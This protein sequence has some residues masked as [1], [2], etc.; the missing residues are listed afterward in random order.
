MIFFAP[1]CVTSL[2]AAVPGHQR[3][4]V[5]FQCLHSQQF[6]QY[7]FRLCSGAWTSTS[8]CPSLSW[9]PS[10]PASA[11]P[12][13]TRGA[14]TSEQG[15]MSCNVTASQIGASNLRST[16]ATQQ[17][18]C[19]PGC[20]VQHAFKPGLLVP[21][22]RV[23]AHNRHPHL[24]PCRPPCLPLLFPHPSAGASPTSPTSAPATTAAAGMPT[25]RSRASPD[26][27]RPARTT[28]RLTR[29]AAMCAAFRRLVPR[30]LTALCS[31]KRVHGHPLH[32]HMPAPPN[33][34]HVCSSASLERV[35][36]S[37]LYNA[38]RACAWA[39]RGQYPAPH[40]HLP[41][42]LHRRGAR[43]QD[44]LHA[45]VREIGR[46]GAVELFSASGR[47]WAAVT[48]VWCLFGCTGGMLYTV[49]WLMPPTACH[50]PLQV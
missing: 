18:C 24:A 2:C 41:A 46:D 34:L 22:S 26:P 17:L 5:H 49:S 42:L 3:V 37:P 28:C 29:C 4:P 15:L 47:D 11:A 20:A 38:G 13:T 10:A 9:T 39:A 8:A 23:Q 21:C 35:N 40:L 27:S 6:F 50:A 43:R 44:Q 25:S 19:L 14:D 12:A 45:Q 16:H 48:G 1:A 30:L 31:S 33:L 32:P 7:S 36:P